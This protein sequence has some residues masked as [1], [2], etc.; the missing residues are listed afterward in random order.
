VRVEKTRLSLRHEEESLMIV[1]IEEVDVELMDRRKNL[2]L[3]LKV[4]KAV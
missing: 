4:Q 1:D 3:P 2:H